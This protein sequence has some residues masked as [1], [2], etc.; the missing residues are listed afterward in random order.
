MGVAGRFWNREHRMYW[1]VFA[2]LPAVIAQN[3][4]PDGPR[5]GGPVFKKCGGG[6]LK[7]NKDICYEVK[8]TKLQFQ[9]GSDGTDD[10]VKVK[11]CDD[12]YKEEKKNACCVTPVLTST[13]SDDFSR[14][15]LETW[16]ENKLGGCR[17]K[18]FTI[19]RGL[20]ITV[21]KKGKDTLKIT[22]LFVDAETVTKDKKKETEGSNV[23]ATPW[24]RKPTPEPQTPLST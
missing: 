12:V 21:S 19:K 9:I 13:L 8:V 10:D 2:L 24:A 23:E 7:G 17:G 14:N 18:K 1:L 11:I 3:N 6:F 16:K 15:D 20:N 4:L 22:S 5:G